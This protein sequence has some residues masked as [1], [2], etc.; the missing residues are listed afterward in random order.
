MVYAVEG[1]V[2]QSARGCDYFV[3]DQ[4]QTVRTTEWKKN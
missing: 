3:R 1:T 2:N 4:E